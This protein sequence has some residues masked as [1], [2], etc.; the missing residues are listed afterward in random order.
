MP[1]LGEAIHATFPDTLI[2]RKRDPIRDGL[3]APEPGDAGQHLGVSGLHG[4]VDHVPPVKA[5]Q[6]DQDRDV[7]GPS[8]IW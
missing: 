8:N 3:T 5:G 1:E 2:R 6:R 4:V 7:A